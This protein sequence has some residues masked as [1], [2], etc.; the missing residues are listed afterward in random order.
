M[1]LSKFNII[2]P[3]QDIQCNPECLEKIAT[4][5]R[6]E[7]EWLYKNYCSKLYNYILLLTNDKALSEDLVQDVFIK[8]WNKRDQ[9]TSVNNF[10]SY[11]FFIAKNL[12]TDKWRRKQME[13]EYLQNFTATQQQTEQNLFHRRNAEQHV[14]KTLKTLSPKQELIYRLIREEGCTREEVSKQLKISPN[15]VKA[16]LQNALHSLKKQ[17]TESTES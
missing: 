14:A 7:F 9:L 2:I 11:L 1:D 15:T 3:P 12:L 10:N 16:T 6:K 4:G 17:L 5:D 13:K 8:I